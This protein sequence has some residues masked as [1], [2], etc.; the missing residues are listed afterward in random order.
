M[1]DT[2][3][4]GIEFAADIL[5]LKPSALIGTLFQGLSAG[6]PH[7][8]WLQETHIVFYSDWKGSLPVSW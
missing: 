5:G 1:Q 8:S 7:G 6:S 2:H 3:W 4:A